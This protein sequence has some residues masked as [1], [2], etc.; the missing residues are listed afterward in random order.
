METAKPD[1]APASRTRRAAQQRHEATVQT[2]FLKAVFAEITGWPSP[3]QSV[4]ASHAG[5]GIAETPPAF[6]SRPG[7]GGRRRP[8]RPTL[9]TP[10]V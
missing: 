2:S 10:V 9:G 8:A 7:P 1:P 3:P 5:D 4:A 6:R